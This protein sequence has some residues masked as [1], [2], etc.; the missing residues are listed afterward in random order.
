[1]RR[2]TRNGESRKVFAKAGRSFTRSVEVLLAAVMLVSVMAGALTARADET[3]GIGAVDKTV[4][5]SNFKEGS[6]S[7][8]QNEH[9]DKPLYQGEDIIIPA[10]DYTDTNTN[11]K[12]FD[13]Y[14]GVKNAVLLKE[15]SKEQEEDESHGESSADGSLELKEYDKA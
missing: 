12:V 10:A 11:I 14:E 15:T 6:Y 2:F 9:A 13:E 8:Y 1:M 3:E 7:A 4:T 5:S